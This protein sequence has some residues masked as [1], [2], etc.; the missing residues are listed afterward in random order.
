M[1]ANKF[2]EEDERMTR[3]Q[4]ASGKGVSTCTVDKGQLRDEHV[5]VLMVD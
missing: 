2:R 5:Y 3:E 1:L 4:N